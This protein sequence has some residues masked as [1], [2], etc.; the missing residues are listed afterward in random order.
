[1]SRYCILHTNQL[2]LQRMAAHDILKSIAS[3]HMCI[4]AKLTFPGFGPGFKPSGR[5]ALVVSRKDT[6]FVFIATVFFPH[7]VIR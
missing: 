3:I 7:Q 4:L 1:M 2:C 5:H 6:L